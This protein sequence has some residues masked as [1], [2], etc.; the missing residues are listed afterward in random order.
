MSAGPVVRRAEVVVA[1]IGNDLR[2]DDGVGPAV[3]RRVARH[4]P[5]PRVAVCALDDPLELL[6]AWEGCHLAV[7]VDATCSGAAPGTV[8]VIDL[9]RAGVTGRSGVQSTHALGVAS[10]LALARALGRAPRRVVLVAVEGA[11]F[12]PGRGLSPAVAAAVAEAAARVV[13]VGLEARPCA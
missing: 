7:V 10:V 5:P 6:W 4:G 2:G 9:G 8:R 3:A 13:E 11:E 12:G 1:G